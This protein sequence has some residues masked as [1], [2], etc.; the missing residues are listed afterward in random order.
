MST[1]KSIVKNGRPALRSPSGKIYYG[2]PAEVR[3]AALM[4]WHRKSLAESLKLQRYIRQKG[5]YTADEFRACCAGYRRDM[6]RQD[7][8][9]PDDALVEI[10]AREYILLCAGSRLVSDSV[11]D[12]FAELWQTEIEALLDVA[13]SETGRREIPLT[14]HERAALARCEEAANTTSNTNTRKEGNQ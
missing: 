8:G 12:F 9:V 14:R 1:W 10:P 5:V 11:K 2:T 3:E 7:G 4:P 13:E 6:V